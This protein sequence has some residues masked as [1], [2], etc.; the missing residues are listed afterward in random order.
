MICERVRGVNKLF[1]AHKD[2][3]SKLQITEVQMDQALGEPA[4]RLRVGQSLACIG[5]IHSGVVPESKFDRYW[6]ATKKANV[7]ATRLK[8]KP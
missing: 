2:I 1:L 7:S 5:H 6:L 8:E 4:T 3:K